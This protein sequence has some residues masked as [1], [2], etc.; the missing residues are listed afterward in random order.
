MDD[1]RQPSLSV[2]PLCSLVPILSYMGTKKSGKGPLFKFRDGCTLTR[3][4]FM[5]KVQEVLQQIG[6]DQ[7]K[8]VGHSFRVSAATTAAEKGLQD[9]LIK[10]Y[11]VGKVWHISYMS[12][13]RENNWL[14]WQLR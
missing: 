13:H 4:R 5:A 1:K 3:E 2:E 6:I 14:Q 9:S 11:G 8:Y 12:E 10:C 7:P